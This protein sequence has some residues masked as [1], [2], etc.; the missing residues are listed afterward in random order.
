MTFRDAL[1]AVERRQLD[2]TVYASDRDRDLVAPFDTRNVTVDYRSLPADAETGFLVLRQRGEFV[3]SIGLDQV[4]EFLDPPIHRPWT[5]DLVGT[6]YRALLG[7]LDDTLCHSLDRRQ[8][9]AT[10]R[11]IE[12]RAWRVGW[13]DLLVGFQRLSAFHDQ[14]S[15]YET[16]AEETDLEIHVYAEVDR[17]L[18]GP[19]N[20]TLHPDPGGEIGDY[21]FLTFDGGGDELQA[22]ALLAEER[23]LG[24]YT[25]FWT[26]DADR[27]DDLAT[28]VRETYD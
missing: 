21:W 13:G 4:R 10:T 28:Y 17:E 26:Y 8:L 27:V 23:D 3:A 25:G 2:L 20:V 18:S 24:A 6:A 22:C 12:N 14:M 16:L 15:V 19:A 9:L 11:E 5:D 7:V 1:D